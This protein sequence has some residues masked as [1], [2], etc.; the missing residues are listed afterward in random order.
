M[1]TNDVFLRPDAGDGTNGVRLRPDAADAGGVTGSLAWTEEND[2]WSI[3]GA[4]TASGSIAWTEANDTWAVTGVLT[5]SAS[6]NWTEADDTWAIT[7]TVTS[8][9]NNGTLAWTEA[10]DVW[11]IQGSAQAEAIAYSGGW[12][13]RYRTR[14]R[15]QIHDERVRLGILP[16]DIVEES[17]D[18]QTEERAAFAFIQELQASIAQAQARQES[19]AAETIRVMREADRAA[20]R[21]RLRALRAQAA[22]AKARIEALR[23]ELD[24]LQAEH[25]ALLVEIEELDVT[26]VALV[27]AN[28]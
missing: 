10:D 15:K 14:T 13:F 20:T 9:T 4:L 23:G 3:T 12:P 26:F 22:E 5:A 17:Q 2:T 21:K 18:A 8:A 19:A 7:G 28:S 16:A 27:L 25:S 6:I 1:A 11:S 24:Q